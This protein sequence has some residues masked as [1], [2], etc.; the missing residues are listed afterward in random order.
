MDTVRILVIDDDQAHREGMVLLLEDE[1]YQVD[2]A[3]GAEPAM[4]L[5]NQHIYNL[6]I[7]DYKMQNL[8]QNKT[9]CGKDQTCCGRDTPCD[10][11]PCDK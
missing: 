9:R 10:K 3:D 6:I 5:I 8:N 1:G 11:P 4:S 2:E 7:T